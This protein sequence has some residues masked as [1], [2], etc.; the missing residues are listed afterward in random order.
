[1]SIWFECYYIIFPQGG[2]FS[3]ESESIGKVTS[4]LNIIFS[5][6]FQVI[7]HLIRLYVAFVQSNVRKSLPVCIPVPV[8]LPDVDGLGVGDV[9]LQ[10][11]LVQEVEEV[12]DCQRDGP[13]GT[14]DGSE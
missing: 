13:A 10:R 4:I 11:L 2:A 3:H 7:I 14:E 12:L 8:G 5:V 1:M 9:V 6:F